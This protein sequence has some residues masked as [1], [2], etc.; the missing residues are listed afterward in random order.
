MLH[1]IF[2]PSL[3]NCFPLDDRWYLNP[4]PAALNGPLLTDRTGYSSEKGLRRTTSPPQRKDNC[5][6][7][8][9]KKLKESLDVISFKN[10]Q[11]QNNVLS[12]ALYHG[13]LL[14]SKSHCRFRVV[15][16]LVPPIN[17]Q[18]DTLFYVIL[19]KVTFARNKL[20]KL[21]VYFFFTTVLLYVKVSMVCPI[22]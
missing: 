18:R 15:F 9:N 7:N 10:S 21:L 16:V 2:F 3:N 17:C 20:R 12:F 6:Q 8:N 4:W 14:C 22:Y 11:F 5:E 19:K 1:L 13:Q